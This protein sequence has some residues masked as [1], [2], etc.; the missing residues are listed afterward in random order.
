M[1]SANKRKSKEMVDENTI[2]N[3]RGMVGQFKRQ[4]FY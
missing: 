3:R 4:N 1:G 2:E